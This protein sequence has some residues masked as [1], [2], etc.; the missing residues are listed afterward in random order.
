MRP[1]GLQNRPSVYD[2]VCRPRPFGTKEH[3]PAFGYT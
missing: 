1:S 3:K 2:K